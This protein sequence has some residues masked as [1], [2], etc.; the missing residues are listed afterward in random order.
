MERSRK[1]S[2]YVGVCWDKRRCRFESSIKVD[3]KKTNIGRFISEID[4]AKSYDSFILTNN[5][6]RKLNF[7]DPEP[8]NLIPNTRLIRLTQGKFAIVDGEDYEKVNNYQWFAWEDKNTWYAGRNYRVSGK[9]KT[10]PMHAFILSTTSQIDHVN[11]NGLHNYRSNL[12]ECT[13]HE[14]SMN[15]MPRINC[16]SKY[17][18]VGKYRD[19]GKFTAKIGYNYK[20]I[21]LGYFTNEIEAAKAYDAK[22]KELFGEF[23]NTNFKN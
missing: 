6:D 1:T 18:G 3:G 11:C 14:N 2:K 7:P 12:R 19:T 15:R 13:S 16:S 5:L 9:R 4:A 10:Q 8:E 22:A 20:T 23:A 21:H 17:K